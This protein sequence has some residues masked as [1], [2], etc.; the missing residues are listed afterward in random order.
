[1]KADK[2]YLDDAAGTLVFKGNAVASQDGVEIFGDSL[3]VKYEGESRDIKR[4]VAKGNV[5]IVQETRTATS[6]HAVFSRDEGRII[7]TGSPKVFQ[8]DNFVQGQEITIFLNE[9]RSIVSGGSGGRVNAI[10][11]PQPEGKP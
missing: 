5:R 10:F 2:L 4:V 6:E 3:T 1:V 8:G 11:T 9:Q 7:L